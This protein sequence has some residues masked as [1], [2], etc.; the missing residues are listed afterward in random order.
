ME[1]SG[2]DRGAGRAHAD[3]CSHPDCDS[4][5]D[6]HADWDRYADSHATWN[7]RSHTNANGIR[8][9]DCHSD[10]QSHPGADCDAYSI[11]NARD[12]CDCSLQ[13]QRE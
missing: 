11:V 12:R 6:R 4:G 7:A 10:G 3:S 9:P 13:L 2:Y 1:F 8:S 5:T